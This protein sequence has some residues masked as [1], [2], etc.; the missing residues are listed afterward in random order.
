MKTSVEVV[1][2]RGWLH[3]RIGAYSRCAAVVAVL[4]VLLAWGLVLNVNNGSVEIPA[5]QVFSMVWDAVRYSLGNLI[6]RGG[7]EEQL[8]GVLN[9][10]TASKIIFS[11][12]IPRMLLAGILGGAL[13]VSGFLLQAF[14]RNP[15]AGPFVLGISSGA[16]MVVGFT[17]VFLSPIVPKMSSVGMVVTAFLGS[18]M[19]VAFILLFSRWVHNMSMLL[20]IGIMISYICGAITDFCITFAKEEDIVNLTNWSMG[21]FSGASWD[22]VGYAAVICLVCMVASWLLSKPIE[23]YALG[24]GYAQSMGINIK[25]FRGVLIVLSSMLSA[26][27][28]AFSGPISFVGIAIPHITRTTLNTSRPAAV[29]PVSYLCGA[30]FCIFCDLLARTVFSPSELAIGTVTSIFG[31]PVVIYMML[32]RRMQKE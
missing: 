28:T 18:L 3:G 14:F 29:I 10:S 26:C 25:L 31:A 20:V 12:R 9:K 22:S 13:A 6:T 4:L 11:I 23:A 24:E 5:S 1:A 19:V 30:V 15:I 21:S 32:K 8:A 7:F 17:M 2:K 16:K 27:V